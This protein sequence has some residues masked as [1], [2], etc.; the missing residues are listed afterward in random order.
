MKKILFT[1]ATLLIATFSFVTP[2]QAAQCGDSGTN[3]YCGEKGGCASDS[4]CIDGWFQDTCEVNSQCQNRDFA[5]EHN[6]GNDGLGYSTH[7][8][9]GWRGGCAEG[10]M[11]DSTGNGKCV[12]NVACTNVD[13]TQN[14]QCGSGNTI[15]DGPNFKCGPEQAG[16]SPGYYCVGNPGAQPD[17]ICKLQASCPTTPIPPPAQNLCGT[18]STDAFGKAC[19]LSDGT[20]VALGGSSVACTASQADGQKCCVSATSCNAVAD[21]VPQNLLCG[22][23]SSSNIDTCP[24]TCNG[25]QLQPFSYSGSPAYCCGWTHTGQCGNQ[26][27]GGT[28]GGCGNVTNSGATCT[29][30]DGRLVNGVNVFQCSNNIARCC[31]SIPQCDTDAGPPA[32]PDTTN[33]CGTLLSATQCQFGDGTVATVRSGSAVACG[34]VSNKC[35]QK[36]DSACTAVANQPPPQDPNVPVDPDTGEEDA[37][38]DLFNIFAGPNSDD[39]SALNPLRTFGDA[40]TTARYFSSPAGIVSRI[41]LFAFPIAGLILFVMLVWAGFQIIAG[42]AQGSKS[43]EAGRQRATTALLGFL[44]LFVSY[45]IMQIIEIVFSITIL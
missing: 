4:I 24:S 40:G 18:I 36:L 12:A 41:L 26:P 44:L 8:W 3:G 33:K 27:P 38:P 42:G 11:C 2:V 14:K 7:N 10:F 39:F 19:A 45:W 13:T 31:E 34:N 25:G 30:D 29:M 35:C 37:A 43:I 9:C 28:G 22:Q 32:N 5:S 16:C 6:C 1:L 15:T 21:P 17:Y 23:Y 20:T